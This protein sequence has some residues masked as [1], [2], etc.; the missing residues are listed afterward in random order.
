MVSSTFLL[1]I[2]TVICLAS[3][4]YTVSIHWLIFS[5]VMSKK[6]PILSRRLA[7]ITAATPFAYATN[8]IYLGN[9]TSRSPSYMIFHRS[10]PRTEP[11]RTPP[12]TLYSFGSSFA[13]YFSTL[14]VK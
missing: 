9:F 6:W 14:F 4:R 3:C 11:R 5:K 13:S 10:G 12:V 7:T 8:M 2:R 1:E